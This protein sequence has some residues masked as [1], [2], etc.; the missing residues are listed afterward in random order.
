MIVITIFN[1]RKETWELHA[2]GRAN[3]I[4]GDSGTG[5][6]SSD[7]YLCWQYKSCVRK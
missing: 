6:V 4:V 7:S 1:F 5:I 3:F 2:H